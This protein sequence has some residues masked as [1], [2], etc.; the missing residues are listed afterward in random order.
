M[1]R[2]I[3]CIAVPSA[4]LY[5]LTMNG[6]SQSPRSR[7]VIKLAKLTVTKGNLDTDSNTIYDAILANSITGCGHKTGNPHEYDNCIAQMLAN[8]SNYDNIYTM[9]AIDNIQ[10]DSQDQIDAL[11]GNIRTL[12]DAND[13][14]AKRV[15]DLETQIKELQKSK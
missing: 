10:K 12:S 8:S 9:E 11:K 4:F 13:G 6:Y 3:L 5:L 2:R 15:G 7:P 1:F 14:L